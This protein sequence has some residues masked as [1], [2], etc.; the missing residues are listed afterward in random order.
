MK[1]RP[2]KMGG[3]SFLL[4][5]SMCQ[6]LRSNICEK[7]LSFVIRHCKALRQIT[8]RRSEFPV[9]TSV[10][11]K[12]YPRKVRIFV[13][14][15]YGNL[16]SLFKNEHTVTPLTE[17]R[18]VPVEPIPAAVLSRTVRGKRIEAVLERRF[19]GF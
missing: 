3:F 11:R 1:I 18:E 17:R 15:A 9:G 13:L 5:P 12:N 7:S 6:F 16:C 10:L 19:A 8:K 14:N 4:T 2:F